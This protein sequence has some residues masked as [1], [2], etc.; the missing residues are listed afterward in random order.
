MYNTDKQQISIFTWRN[1]IC[2]LDWIYNQ[3]TT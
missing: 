2:H 3:M 1:E